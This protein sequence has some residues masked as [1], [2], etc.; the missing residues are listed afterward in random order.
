MQ[1]GDLEQVWEE[2]LGITLGVAACIGAPNSRVAALRG[3]GPAKAR[4]QGC[5]ASLVALNTVWRVGRATHLPELA[6]YSSLDVGS[7]QKV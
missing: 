7:L 3:L 2:V 4:L 1:G 6:G 5:I